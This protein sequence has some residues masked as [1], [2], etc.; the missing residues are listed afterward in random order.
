MG[1]YRKGT[2]FKIKDNVVTIFKKDKK[3]KTENYYG[4]FSLDGQQYE[5]TS[6][7]SNKIHMFHR[8]SGYRKFINVCTTPTSKCQ[9]RFIKTVTDVED[10]VHQ[11]CTHISQKSSVFD[12]MF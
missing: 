9:I 12:K 11:N 5:F 8:L 10:Y 3:Y 1:L 6:K 4:R 2:D 7:T